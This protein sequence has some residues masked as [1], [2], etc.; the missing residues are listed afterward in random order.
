VLDD[1]AF[2]EHADALARAKTRSSIRVL[3]G[4]DV[5]DAQGFVVAQAADISPYARPSRSC[6]S[7]Q[8]IT[9]IPIWG[10]Y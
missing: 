4:G 7:R 8:L 9:D 6:S 3:A 1:K 10:N 5:N 2:A